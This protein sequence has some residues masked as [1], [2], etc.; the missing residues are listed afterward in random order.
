MAQTLLVPAQELWALC[1]LLGDM[2]GCFPEQQ[3][4]LAGTEAKCDLSYPFSYW[5]KAEMNN[6]FSIASYCKLP[7]QML[8]W[9][10]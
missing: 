9:M 4:C 8:F 6:M 5:S 10:L 1:S 3:Y 7:G 2:T